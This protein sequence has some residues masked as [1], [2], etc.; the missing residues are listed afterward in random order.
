MQP[1]RARH[2]APA[3]SGGG[4]DGQRRGQDGGDDP[5]G[6][7]GGGGGGGGGEGGAVPSN[8]IATRGIQH[9]CRRS[10][11]WREAVGRANSDIGEGAGERVGGEDVGD[12]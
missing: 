1:P 7:G 10:G 2:G 5:S 8:L 3:T 9:G 6:D 4:A 11:G 12:E